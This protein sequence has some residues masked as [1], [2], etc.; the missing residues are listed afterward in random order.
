MA[1]IL[2]LSWAFVAVEMFRRLGY[3]CT[4]AYCRAALFGYIGVQTPRKAA[5]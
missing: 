2:G 5:A 3:Y 1:K 4:V